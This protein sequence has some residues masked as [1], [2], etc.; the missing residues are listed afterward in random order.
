MDFTK[1][2][3]ALFKGIIG[4]LM[5]SVGVAQLGCGVVRSSPS[6]PLT[7][8]KFFAGGSRYRVGKPGADFM[9]TSMSTATTNFF[10][11][12]QAG[13]QWY[14]FNYVTSSARSVRYVVNVS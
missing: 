13:F 4:F 12:S 5:Q 6:G 8:A 7:L 14:G 11:S 2:G 3:S 1:Q 10:F 9:G